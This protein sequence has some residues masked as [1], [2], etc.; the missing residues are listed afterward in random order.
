MASDCIVIGGGVIGLGI[1]WRLSREGVKVRVFEKEQ[2][3]RAASWFAAGM[4]A[5]QA[6]VGFE[7]PELFELSRESL[8]LF[9]GML[10]ELEA[11][12]GTRVA[13]DRCGTLMVGL[14]R[15][16]VERL[17]RVRRFRERIGLETRWLTGSEAREREPLL[18]SR[19]TA[20]MWLPDDAQI[21]NRGL[22]QTL[23]AACLA[24]GA[25][26]HENEPVMDVVSRGGRIVGVRT[27][28][29][30]IHS[31]SVVLSAGCWSSKIGGIPEEVLPPVRPVK[32]Q[33]LS[34]RMDETCRPACLIRAPDVYLVP[35]S[36]GRLV[37]GATSEEMGFDTS[38]T[39]GGVYKLLERAW[40]AMPAIYELNLIE[41]GVGLRPASRDHAP[42]VGTTDIEG[43]YYAT[44]HY[45]HG[46]LLSAV[47][48][49]G[50]ADIVLRGKTPDCLAPFAASR[51]CRSEIQKVAAV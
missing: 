35:K 11:E 2:T 48:A 5:P 47:T 10:E 8:R 17:Q 13:F 27:A 19:A 43:L 29:E 18:S 37:V 41:V 38:P 30:E 33:I 46:I 21:D 26:I 20:A 9:P 24:S 44:G 49:Y 39:A 31:E 40:E 51:F 28:K 22:V 25:E 7:E 15:D 45:R 6:E 14:D 4:L 42:I 12:T 32:G 16:D 23:K 34:L 3:G 36:D 50:M 1:A